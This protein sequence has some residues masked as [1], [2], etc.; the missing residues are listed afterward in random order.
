[1]ST[2]PT[3]RNAAAQATQKLHDVIMPDMNSFKEQMKKSQK[4]GGGATGMEKDDREMR[5]TSVGKRRKRAFEV[6]SD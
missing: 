1:M 3:R 4:S 6:R 5:E 2:A